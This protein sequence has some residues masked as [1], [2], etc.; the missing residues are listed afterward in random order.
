MFVVCARLFFRYVCVF[1]NWICFFVQS[2]F[3]SRG[4]LSV[5]CLFGCLLICVFVHV[6]VFLFVGFCVVCL[7][8]CC[9]CV[10]RL[11]ACVFVR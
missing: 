6:F 5:F 3:C 1:V 10:F 4:C 9:V 8:M 11:L 7:F 2:E